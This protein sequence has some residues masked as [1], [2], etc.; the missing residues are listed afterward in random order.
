M[1]PHGVTNLTWPTPP[2]DSI[3]LA[4]AFSRFLSERSAQRKP[5]LAQISFHN[6]HQPFIAS[7]SAKESCAAGQTCR[8]PSE[9]EPPYTDEELD[10][11]ACLTELDNAV[12]VILQ[13]LKKH[14]YY[15]NTMT[16]FA[17]DNGPEKNCFP[18]GICERADTNP[19][20]PAEGPGSSGPLRGR[21]RDIYEGGHRV[22]AFISYPA[23]VFGG[24]HVSWETVTTMDY[25]PT[26]MEILG[27]ER[28]EE[29]QSWS[30]DGRSVLQLLRSPGTFQWNHTEEGPRE[31]GFGFYPP[32]KKGK[33][34]KHSRLNWGYRFGKWKYVEGSSSCK[35]DSCR[36]PQLYDLE[37]DLGERHDLSLEYPDILA[38]VQKKFQSF[39]DSVM[40]SRLI[41]SKCRHTDPLS[42]PQSLSTERSS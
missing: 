19:Q 29:Q 30:L 13:A 35:I 11:Y 12:S 15:E 36:K 40:V 14:G 7:K 32:H 9:G 38:D 3:Y 26:I 21:K 37:N 39:Y 17:T 27:V 22:P 18:A 23:E 6:C 8:P 25:L 33:H 28:P 42:L 1:A 41:E 31:I 24:D 10:Y 16:W 34:R 4:D 5:F 2:D 20:R